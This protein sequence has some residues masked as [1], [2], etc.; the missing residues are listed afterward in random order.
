MHKCHLL[1]VSVKLEL[2]TM[3]R[4]PPTH[5][6]L[7][8]Y[9]LTLH[10]KVDNQTLT[11]LSQYIQLA[12]LI[13]SVWKLWYDLSLLRIMLPVHWELAFLCSNLVYNKLLISAKL[14]QVLVYLLPCLFDITLQHASCYI[15]SMHSMGRRVIAQCFN[16]SSTVIIQKL[17]LQSTCGRLIDYTVVLT[18]SC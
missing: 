11:L 9:D 7:C 8:P 17:Y 6:A 16:M 1:S 2:L 10:N 5:E 14:L 3:T 18:H 4:I 15:C 13:Y 12:W